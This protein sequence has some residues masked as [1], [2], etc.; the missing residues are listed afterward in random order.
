MHVYTYMLFCR[1]CGPLLLWHITYIPFL[2]WCCFASSKT[3]RNKQTKQKHGYQNQHNTTTS[4]HITTHTIIILHRVSCPSRRRCVVVCCCAAAPVYIYT[5]T[6]ICVCCRGFRSF[7]MPSLVIMIIMWGWWPSHCLCCVYIHTH[8]AKG[9][10]QQREKRREKGHERKLLWDGTATYSL[11]LYHTTGIHT[12]TT[13]IYRQRNKATHHP[14]GDDILLLLWC[15]VCAAWLGWLVGC[16]IVT[17][18]AF[19]CAITVFFCALWLVCVCVVCMMRVR[20]IYI[21][22]YLDR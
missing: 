11:V 15:H 22:I 20:Y 2:G 14:L 13:Y 6:C 17:I 7:M 10:Q 3:H 1:D 9:K 18:I 8:R 19:I 5:H 12:H 16:Y 21:Y 4:H